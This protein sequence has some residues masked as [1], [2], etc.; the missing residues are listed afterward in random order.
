MAIHLELIPAP[1][2]GPW[3]PGRC[4]VPRQ[5]QSGAFLRPYTRTWSV[6]ADRAEL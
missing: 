5:S 3:L 2:Q 1:N 6:W 4:Q